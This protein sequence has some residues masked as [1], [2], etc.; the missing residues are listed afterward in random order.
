MRRA[1]CRPH[2]CEERPCGCRQSAPC[3]G[4]VKSHRCFT[5]T[6]GQ[7]N[8]CPAY[9]CRPS[10]SLIQQ[11]LRFTDA[12]RPWDRPRRPSTPRAAGRLRPSSQGF[13]AAA[14]GL[15]RDRLRGSTHTSPDSAPVHWPAPKDEIEQK[16]P[17]AFLR[18]APKQ[19]NVI[20]E[21]TDAGAR[22]GNGIQVSPYQ[23]ARG[24]GEERP[25]QGAPL[26][27]ARLKCHC[28]DLLPCKYIGNLQFMVQ[29]LHDVAQSNWHTNAS[30]NG[31]IHRHSKLGK[32]AWKSSRRVRCPG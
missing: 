10:D 22:P 18:A 7:L 31:N 4:K 20:G 24:G 8:S 26:F 3:I 12:R 14:S 27:D 13:T 28:G 6:H 19:G 30:Q 5:D 2:I 21:R 16:Q 29:C 1:S 23:R 11:V 17:E 9:A 25:R 32:A 15:R